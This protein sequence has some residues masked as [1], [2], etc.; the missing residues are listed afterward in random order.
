[1]YKLSAFLANLEKAH[2]DN[3]T[4]TIGGGLFEP[5]DYLLIIELLNETLRKGLNHD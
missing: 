4:L 1:M 2:R 3:D 5:E